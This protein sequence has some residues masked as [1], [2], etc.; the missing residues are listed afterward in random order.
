MSIPADPQRSDGKI[1][2]KFDPG[3]RAMITTAAVNP[4]TAASPPQ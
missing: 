2:S 3:F 1:A 4:M